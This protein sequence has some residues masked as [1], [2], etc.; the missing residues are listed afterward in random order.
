[1]CCFILAACMVGYNYID[2]YK[3]IV[4]KN[5]FGA[6]QKNTQP[7]DEVDID[8]DSDDG[9]DN[10]WNSGNS[11][12]PSQLLIEGLIPETLKH[13]V[14]QRNVSNPSS[15]KIVSTKAAPS[16]QNGYANTK[17]IRRQDSNDTN[18]SENTQSVIVLVLVSVRGTA[19]S[20]FL[21]YFCTLAIF[22]VWTSELIST[23]QCDT[24]SRIRN[25]LFVPLSFVVFN[26]GDLIG[27]Y[28]S[29]TIR[30]EL[31]SNLS[32]KLVWASATRVFLF[33]YLFLWCQ[34]RRNRYQDWIFVDNDLFSWSIQLFFA[35]TNGMLTNIAF[36]YA[37]TLIENRTNPQQVASAILNLAMTLG[38]TVGS[39]FS[40]PF[41]KFA[42]GA[43]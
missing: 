30:F 33:F 17:G 8:G 12:K 40:G 22:P 23:Q 1:M 2:R 43:S 9:N 25:D 26:S 39:F 6:R 10:D 35:I 24:P 28:I 37:P 5:S 14:D 4:R 21:T 16:Y 38:L 42:S 7:R 32:R 27:R 31:I 15:V 41:L 36:C 11:D 29:S 34:A 3:Q 19:L 20:L 18:T 13:V